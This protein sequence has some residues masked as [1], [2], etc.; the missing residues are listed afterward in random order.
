MTP[1]PAGIALETRKTDAFHHAIA[2]SSSALFGLPIS[3]TLLSTRDWAYLYLS[4]PTQRC[5]AV[6]LGGIDALG[7]TIDLD[8]QQ[9]ANLQH[10]Y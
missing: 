3:F 6:R 5:I 4:C 2:V 1:A 9:W 7:H 10:K 8:V